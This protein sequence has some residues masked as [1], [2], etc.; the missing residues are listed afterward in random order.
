MTNYRWKRAPS[1]LLESKLF[2]KVSQSYLHIP[3]WPSC[4]DTLI[5][6]A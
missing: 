1:L 6:W 5:E 3:N 4:I 2:T